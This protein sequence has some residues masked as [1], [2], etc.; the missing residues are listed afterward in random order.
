MR[1]GI[2]L[3]QEIECVVGEHNA[4]APGYVFRVA[5]DDF[6]F[7]VDEG[8]AQQDSGVKSRGAGADDGNAHLNSPYWVFAQGTG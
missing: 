8:P 2:V 5:F 1:F 3:G 7:G 6:D 4:E